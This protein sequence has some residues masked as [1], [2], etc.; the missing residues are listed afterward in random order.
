MAAPV[1]A[2]TVAQM[3]PPACSGML[4]HKGACG[5]LLQ[6]RCMVTE[7]LAKVPLGALDA[8]STGGV[9]TVLNE[10]IGK[11]E[12]ALAHSLSES[13]SYLTGLVVIF[14]Y[15]PVKMHPWSWC[16]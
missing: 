2:G 10:D 12:P 7:H 1:N 15:L 3:A 9:K 14:C 6:V 16:L 5:L 4:S 13:V 8:R 11:L